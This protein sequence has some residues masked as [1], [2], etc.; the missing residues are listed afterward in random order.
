MRDTRPQ[1]NVLLGTLRRV[2]LFTDLSNAE[3]VLVAEHATVRRY[4]HGQVIFTEGDA[5]SELLIVREGSVRILK[6]AAN[7]RRQLLSIE[8]VGNSLSELSV[9]DGNPYPA[10]AEAITSTTL[11]CLAADHFRRICQQNPDV[12]L[13]V[14]KVLGHR[15]RRMAELI[16]EL[17]FSTVRGRLVSHLL[18]LAQENG[19]Q[20]TRGI[21]VDLFENNEELAARL[22]T[23]RELVSRNLGRLHNDGLIEVRRRLVIIPNL[24]A[25]R[26]EL[27]AIAQS[28]LRPYFSL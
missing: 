9:F 14:I 10:T 5:C 20:S 13:K 15:L 7:G 27:A 4:D 18:R 25:L 2:P 6:T 3:L 26:N 1:F 21:V 12:A 19:R 11:L 28:R 22:G 16:E 17:S 8:R 24:A 23:V